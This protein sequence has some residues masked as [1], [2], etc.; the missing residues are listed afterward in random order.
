MSS[1]Q[2]HITRPGVDN[3]LDDAFNHLQYAKNALNEIQ[4][5]QKAGDLDPAAQVNVTL[6]MCLT[7][8]VAAALNM[9]MHIVPDWLPDPDRLSF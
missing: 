9:V 2:Y 4:R 8:I 1:K 3:R 5:A 7:D 6:L